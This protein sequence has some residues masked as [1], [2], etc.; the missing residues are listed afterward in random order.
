[1]FRVSVSGWKRRAALALA[2]AAAAAEQ[3]CEQRQQQ[4]PPWRS[5]AMS[6][7][8]LALVVEDV[9]KGQKLAFRYPGPRGQPESVSWEMVHEEEADKELR[10]SAKRKAELSSLTESSV[11]RTARPGHEPSKAN[12]KRSGRKRVAHKD[13]WR[14]EPKLFTK[15]FR[16][17]PAMCGRVFELTVDNLHFLCFPAQISSAVAPTAPD[18]AGAAAGGAG[19]G[20]G[21]GGSGS[22]GSSTGISASASTSASAS[23]I[24]TF[25]AQR[26]CRDPRRWRRWKQQCHH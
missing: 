1:V 11:G 15:I 25:G 6:L 18:V 23:S 17:T 5:H 7:V 4:E 24:A 19:G 10:G 26:G 14:F 12:G 21:I 13:F 2:A 9:S 16:P 8:G 3:A 22:S 20:T